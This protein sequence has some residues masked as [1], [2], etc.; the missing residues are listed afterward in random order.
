MSFQTSLRT[1]AHLGVSEM[2]CTK[3]LGQFFPEYGGAEVYSE[4][5][6]NGLQKELQDSGVPGY[7]PKVR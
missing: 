5:D 6:G 2:V 1:T 4:G 7:H 3:A